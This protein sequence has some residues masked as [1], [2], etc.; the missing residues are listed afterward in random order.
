[1][2]KQIPFKSKPRA[3]EAIPFTMWEALESEQRSNGMVRK[4]HMRFDLNALADFEQETGMGF[5][6]LM[7]TKAIFATARALAWAGLRHEDRTLSVAAVGEKLQ[8]FLR[9]GGEIN[10]VLTALFQIAKEQ[11][12]FGKMADE[13]AEGPAEDRLLEDGTT[14][15]GT[16]VQGEAE[17]G[18]GLSTEPA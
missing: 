3:T 12:A 4:R 10:D 7:N 13:P 15:E 2:S 16:A 5:G 14:I 1:M 18:T 9:A 11:G 17:A 6:Q 8:E